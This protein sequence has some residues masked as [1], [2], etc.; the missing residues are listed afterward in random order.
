MEYSEQ[1][2]V[3]HN[4]L[5]QLSRHFV[6]PNMCFVPIGYECA[7]WGPLWVRNTCAY[8]CVLLPDALHSSAY[9]Y[10]SISA[11]FCTLLP[12]FLANMKSHSYMGIEPRKMVN[13]VM[14][15]W[16]RSPH[17]SECVLHPWLQ[18]PRLRTHIH[19]I[20]KEYANADSSKNRFFGTWKKR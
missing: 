6:P 3:L 4:G 19:P 12:C 16:C 11:N 17:A 7:C 9:S 1:G 2:Q 14:G 5:R 20:G 15:V 13:P 18:P 10:R 8:Y